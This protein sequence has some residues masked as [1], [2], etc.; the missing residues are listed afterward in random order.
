MFNIEFRDKDGILV[1][2]ADY[3]FMS[4]YEMDDTATGEVGKV[5]AQVPFDSLWKQVASVK[6]VRQK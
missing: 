3:S 6:I 4:S 5:K 1:Q 2:P